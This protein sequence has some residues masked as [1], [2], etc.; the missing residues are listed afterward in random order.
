MKSLRARLQH[1]FEVDPPGPAEPT[2]EQQ[3][4][5]DW[6]CR[7][8]AKR[9]LTTPGLIALEM[10]RPLNWLGAQALHF[11]SPFVWSIAA[12][13]SYENYCH[14]ARFVEQ[15][16]AVDYLVRRIEELEHEMSHRER[17]RPPDP[18]PTS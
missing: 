17:G 8:V 18:P 12:S 14:F 1:A 2:E 4:S 10:C 5:V 13:Q 15:R 3:P 6:V 11:A 7:Q 9:H 16:G